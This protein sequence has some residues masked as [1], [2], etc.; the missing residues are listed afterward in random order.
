MLDFL[1]NK[2]KIIFG[3]SDLLPFACRVEEGYVKLFG[4]K[5]E[6][7]LGFLNSLVS[8]K[9]LNMIREIMPCNLRVLDNCLEIG[10]GNMN[11]VVHPLTSLLNMGWIENSKGDFYF[12][13]EG[14][15]TSVAKFL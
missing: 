12:Y 1:N 11:G 7:S 3:D 4:T 13:K 6:I 5:R 2:V 14:I 15:S 9:D 8:E 10:L